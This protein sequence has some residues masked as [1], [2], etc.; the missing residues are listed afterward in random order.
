MYTLI[1]IYQELNFDY[2]Y[3]RV[4]FWQNGS[5]STYGV[6]IWHT[7]KYLLCLKI[8]HCCIDNVSSGVKIAEFWRKIGEWGY[9]SWNGPSRV[10]MFFHTVKKRDFNGTIILWNVLPSKSLHIN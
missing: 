2:V 10:S 7:T 5:H 1:I 3:R 6:K 4:S 9:G 8:L